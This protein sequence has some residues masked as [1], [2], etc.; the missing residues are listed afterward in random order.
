ME[1]PQI[2]GTI[3]KKFS[4]PSNV[5]WYQGSVNPG[6]TGPCSFHLHDNILKMEAVCSSKTV[7]HVYTRLQG[8]TTQET[9]IWTF[10]YCQEITIWTFNYCQETTTRTFTYYM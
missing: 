9:T 3:I 5:T 1:D 2:S 10:I 7:V 8:I 6:V 4:C